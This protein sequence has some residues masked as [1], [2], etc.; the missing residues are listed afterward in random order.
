M[1][2]V[3]LIGRRGKGLAIP[4]LSGSQACRSAYT[5]PS[6]ALSGCPR[7]SEGPACEGGLGAPHSVELPMHT[8]AAR[9]AGA[10][11]SAILSPKPD[12]ACDRE[13]MSEVGCLERTR[14]RGN[15]RCRK[16]PRTAGGLTT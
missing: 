4:A 11:P 10:R 15:V 13:H 14:A 1:G 2:V 12:A 9:H 5:L 6:S 7:F 16:P 3:F 8:T